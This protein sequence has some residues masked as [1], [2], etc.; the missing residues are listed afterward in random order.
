MPGS[1]K[2]EDLQAILQT[3]KFCPAA[4]LQNHGVIIT[5]RNL[6]DAIENA[7]VVEDA[8]KIA[9][10]SKNV[11]Q[12]KALSDAEIYDLIDLKKSRYG[13]VKKIEKSML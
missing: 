6:K 9:F 1:E 5:G 13:Q 8:A 4:L 2:E 3:L 12:P 10:V 11:G 7:I